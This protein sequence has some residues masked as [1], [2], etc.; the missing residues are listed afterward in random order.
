MRTQRRDTTYDQ[1]HS[2]VEWTSVGCKDQSL[3]QSSSLPSIPSLTEE[4]PNAQNRNTNQRLWLQAVT[5][6]HTK[7]KIRNSD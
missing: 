1:T 2:G 4:M 5:L 6:K 3:K 7:I